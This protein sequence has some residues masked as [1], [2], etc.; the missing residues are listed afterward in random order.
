MPNHKDKDANLE[1]SKL[2]SLVTEVLEGG[3]YTHG[4][5]RVLRHLSKEIALFENHIEGRKELRIPRDIKMLDSI[6]IGGGSH[7]LNGFFNIDVV[8]PADLIC[9]VRE[10]LPLPDKC[11]HFIFTEHFLEHIDYPVSVK[12]VV[13][14]MYRVLAD[15][16]RAVVGVPDGE[17]AVKAYVDRDHKYFKR[18]METWY[19]NRKCLEHFNTYIDLLNY[20][21]RDQDDDVKYTPHLWAYD[22]EK[23][24][25]LF[26][27][28]GFST[29]V[30]WV[31]DPKI[32]NPKREYGSV[33]V[34]AT[35]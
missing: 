6:Q 26:I 10:G 19:A 4:L 22:F 9:D 11:S 23:L 15:G 33:Y 29:V 5:G 28:A 2:K 24:K 3:V 20:H 14:E 25:S 12:K 27:S 1:I 34:I 35:K 16:G 13:S 30:P 18:A 8:P 21:F 17:L 32:A 31:F 7:M